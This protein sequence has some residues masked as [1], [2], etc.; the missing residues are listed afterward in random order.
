MKSDIAPEDLTIIGRKLSSSMSVKNFKVPILSI[1]AE[2]I[3]LPDLTFAYKDDIWQVFAYSNSASPVIAHEDILLC[4]AYLVWNGIFDPM[5]TRMQ[6]NPT[7]V[8]IQEIINM[9]RM[10]RDVFGTYEIAQVHFS[11][12]LAE[13]VITKMLVMVSFEEAS[14]GMEFSSLGIIYKNNWEEKIGR[15][16]CRERVYI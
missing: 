15:A 8:T 9:G 6:P 1:S 2:N 12:F 16:S 10:I 4:L 14:S 5:Q 11:K 7:S 13:E 3:K